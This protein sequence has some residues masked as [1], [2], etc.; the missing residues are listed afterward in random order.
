[1]TMTQAITTRTTTTRAANTRAA[2]TQG[3]TTQTAVSQAP[4]IFTPS[5]D[6]EAVPQAEIRKAHTSSTAPRIDVINVSQ[7]TADGATTLHEIDLV[8]HPGEIIAIAGGSGAGKTTLLDAIAGLRPAAEGRVLL[9]GRHP[10]DAGIT[11]GYVPQ[12]DIIH[13][14]LPLRRTLRY[15]AA[16]RLPGAGGDEIDRAVERVLRQLGLAQ[17]ADVPVRLLSG[18]QRKRASIAAELLTEPGVFFL[19]EPTSGLDPATGVEVMRQLRELAS[20]N[21]TIVLTSH[22]PADLINCDRIVFLASDGHLAFVGTTDEALAYF[23]VTDLALI[24]ERLA[25]ESDPSVWSERLRQ[26]SNHPHGAP[27]PAGLEAEPKRVRR[28][29]LFRQ[30]RTLTAR[31]TELLFRNRLTLAILLGSP[32]GVVAMMA[33]LFRPGTFDSANVSSIPAIQTLFWVAFASFFFGVTYGLLQIVGE[34]EIFR[35]ERFGGLSVG[36]YVASKMA[37]LGPLLVF[38]NVA[39][40]AILRTL[41]R[42][43]SAST[44]AWAEILT[45][46]VLISAAAVALGLL[47]SASVNN[48]AQ[49]TLALPML[50]FPQ[51]LFAGAVVPIDEMSAAGRIMSLWLADRWGFEALGRSL[52]MEALVGNDPAATGWVGAFTGNP[53]QAWVILSAITLGALVATVIVLRRRSPVTATRP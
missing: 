25:S 15:A 12:D 45:T 13:L 49:A 20:A 21:T 53:Y 33:V 42:L 38:V 44:G 34:F 14:E 40:L 30:W 31:S 35:R 32:V 27:E 43:P 37:I 18:G 52:G 11:T 41:D 22:A 39:M 50:C 10:T 7:R 1:M 47:A 51:V 4:G 29:G 36:A 17:R 8:V 23:E 46:S 24:Y 28:V 6:E 2:N 9:D 16:L 5:T 26:S 19:D 3:T 48:P